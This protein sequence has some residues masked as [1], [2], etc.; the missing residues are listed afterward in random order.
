M[1]RNGVTKLQASDIERLLKDN[2]KFYQIADRVRKHPTCISKEILNNRI[3]HIP[4]DFNNRTNHC[5]NMSLISHYDILVLLV[6][7][8]LLV[9]TSHH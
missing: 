9:I 8:V 6:L 1:K 2:F 3:Q 7:L 4:P 5:K